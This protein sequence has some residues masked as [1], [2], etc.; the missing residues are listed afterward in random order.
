MGAK[1][2]DQG[3]HDRATSYDPDQHD[4]GEWFR[5]QISDQEWHDYEWVRVEGFGKPPKYV[6]GFKR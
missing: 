1:K 3:D 6:R 2:T 5:E 4:K